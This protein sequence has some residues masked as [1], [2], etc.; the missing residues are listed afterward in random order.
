M[1]TAGPL[2]GRLFVHKQNTFEVTFEKCE[3]FCEA[4]SNT[5]LELLALTTATFHI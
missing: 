1:L 4:R 2:K 5:A 3:I